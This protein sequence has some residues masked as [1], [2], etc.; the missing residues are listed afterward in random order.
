MKF[1]VYILKISDDQYYIGSTSN[2]DRRIKEHKLGNH[3]GTRY[4]KLIELLLVQ[5]YSSSSLA[6]KVER[7]LKSFKSKRI[8]KKIINDGKIILK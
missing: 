5:E 7:K 6:K 2:I 3:A 4:S 1:F 8:I